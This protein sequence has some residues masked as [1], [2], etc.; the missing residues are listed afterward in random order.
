MPFPQLVKGARE[1][2]AIAGTG[3]VLNS[4]D[5]LS[6]GLSAALQWPAQ[7]ALS[8]AFHSI[9]LGLLCC[10]HSISWPV[11]VIFHRHH[12]II[13]LPVQAYFF[14]FPLLP[15]DRQALPPGPSCLLPSQMLIKP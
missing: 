1:D 8:A 9:I 7:V 5:L 13:S 15:A 14:G 4:Q 2:S 10:L 12:V 11:I 3:I 6:S